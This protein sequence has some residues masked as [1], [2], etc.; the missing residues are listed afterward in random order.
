MIKYSFI[1]SKE[2][3][4]LQQSDLNASHAL[5][6]SSGLLFVIFQFLRQIFLR[7]LILWLAHDVSVELDD[8]GRLQSAR[9]VRVEQ[10]EEA[11]AHVLRHLHIIPL[12]V[13]HFFDQVVENFLEVVIVE[14]ASAVHF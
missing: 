1:T 7:L 2:S 8:F 13:V 10:A 3:L 4:R 5:D 12:Y 9:V 14:E 6:E 11:P